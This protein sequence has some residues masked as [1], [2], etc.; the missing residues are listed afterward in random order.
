MPL[1]ICLFTFTSFQRWRRLPKCNIIKKTLHSLLLVYIIATVVVLGGELSHSSPGYKLQLP[2]VCFLVQMFIL[3]LRGHVS[4]QRDK[5]DVMLFIYC[6]GAIFPVYPQSLN[7]AGNTDCYTKRVFCQGLYT[8]GVGAA[9]EETQDSR[10]GSKRFGHHHGHGTEGTTEPV[11]K[12]SSDRV[13]WLLNSLFPV[14]TVISLQ[15]VFVSLLSRDSVYDVLRR[16][17][18]HLQVCGSSLPLWQEVWR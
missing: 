2:L 6:K 14:N 5:S 1:P 11:R 8:G 15:Y 4:S 7:W 9:G 12:S 13:G 10:P 16:I 18:T 17:C 3:L